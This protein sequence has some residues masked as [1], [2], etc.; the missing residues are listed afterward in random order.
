MVGFALVEKS[1]AAIILI[2]ENGRVS[3]ECMELGTWVGGILFQS[4]KHAMDSALI[5]LL[6]KMSSS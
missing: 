6:L 2:N 1:K 4:E 3:E 5:K